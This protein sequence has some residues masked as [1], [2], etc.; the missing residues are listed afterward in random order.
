MFVQGNTSQSIRQLKAQF[1]DKGK[2]I[3]DAVFGA[4]VKSEKQLGAGVFN[5]FGRGEN[6]FNVSSIQFALHY[7]FEN[8]ESLQNFLTNISECTQVEGYFIGTCFD[9]KKI[10]NLLKDKKVNES[11]TIMNGD[12][13]ITE[14]TKKY[15]RDEFE[16][17]NDCVGYSIEVYQESIN[18]VFKEYLVNFDYLDQLMENYGFARLTDDELKRINLPNSVGSFSDL[19]Y[20]METELKMNPRNA[21]KYGQSTKISDQE[22]AVS[23]LNNYFIYKKNRPVDIQDVKKAMLEKNESEIK[24][25]IEQA[26]I[27][28]QTVKSVVQNKTRPVAVKKPRKAKLKIEE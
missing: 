20:L 28:Q 15:D 8:N 13:K 10:F 3:T 16:T 1:T 17:N 26:L 7:M 6:G 25:E 24:G 23:F 4:G 14:I 27:A 21:N 11:Y 2:Q 12:K 22:K 19:Y 18:K 5:V 9:G